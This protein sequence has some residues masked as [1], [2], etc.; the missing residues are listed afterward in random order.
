MK[1]KKH[2]ATDV[3]QP[4]ARATQQQDIDSFLRALYSYPDRFAHQPDLSFQQYLLSIP[5]PPDTQ[6]TD[7]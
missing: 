2:H 1:T 3:Q 7:K 4:H 6:S 5:S